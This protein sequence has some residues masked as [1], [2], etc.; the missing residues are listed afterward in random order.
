MHHRRFIVKRGEIMVNYYDIVK[1]ITNELTTT[2]NQIDMNEVNKL[3]IE[4]K[5]Q[6]KYFLSG[7]EE[8]YYL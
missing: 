4:I 6:I 7:L 8:F 3:L 5:K 2:L 1:E